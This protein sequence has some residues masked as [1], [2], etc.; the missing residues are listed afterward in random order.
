MEALLRLRDEL[1]WSCA[2][3]TGTVAVVSI[4]IAPLRVV[5]VLLL[6]REP[7]TFP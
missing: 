3:H 1:V 7:E 4:V 2:V 5:Q 6:A